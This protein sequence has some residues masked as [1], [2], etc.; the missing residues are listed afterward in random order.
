M[1]KQELEDA[2]VRLVASARRTT[3]NWHEQFSAEQV[4]QLRNLW[5]DGLAEWSQDYWHKGD[6]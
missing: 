4:E 6:N 5:N 2:V 3:T 1:K